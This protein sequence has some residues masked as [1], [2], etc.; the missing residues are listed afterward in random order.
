[1]RQSAEHNTPGKSGERHRESR[2]PSSNGRSPKIMW[3][4]HSWYSTESGSVKYRFCVS[5]LLEVIWESLTNT[6]GAN[7]LVM[8]VSFLHTGHLIPSSSLIQLETIWVALLGAI[9]QNLLCKVT[10]GSEPLVLRGM[11]FPRFTRW[12]GEEGFPYKF[13]LRSRNDPFLLFNTNT[14]TTKCQIIMIDSV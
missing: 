3:E 9:F 5:V 2:C 13:G 6:E 14:R 4:Q 11:W 7:A 8:E 1:M 12:A 10:A